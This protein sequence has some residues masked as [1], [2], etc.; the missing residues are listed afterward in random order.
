MSKIVE[1]EGEQKKVLK[2]VV[3][4]RLVMFA[5]VIVWV[6]GWLSAGLTFMPQLFP[7]FWVGTFPGNPILAFLFVWYVT[8]FI[9]VGIWAAIKGFKFVGRWE[10]E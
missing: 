3:A 1:E 9:S 6:L 2:R 4:A 8:T 7:D 10:K 5:A